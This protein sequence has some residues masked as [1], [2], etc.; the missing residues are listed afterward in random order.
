[1][2][3]Y[4]ERYPDKIVEYDDIIEDVEVGDSEPKFSRKKIEFED[5]LLG[6]STPL[7]DNISPVRKCIDCGRKLDPGRYRHCRKCVVTLPSD[8]GD[9]VYYGG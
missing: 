9:T 1:M 8:D 7:L 5:T 3:T 2:K 6:P 4:K